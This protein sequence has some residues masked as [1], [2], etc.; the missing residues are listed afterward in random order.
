MKKLFLI[1]GSGFIFRAFY[2]LPPL[3]NPEGTPINAVYGY[4]NMI[5]NIYEKFK[6]EQVIV[7]F[8]TKKKTFRNE[9]YKQYKSNRSEPPEELIPQFSIIREATDALQIPRV[10]I[11]G[12]EADDIIATYAKRAEKKGISVTI[13][14]SDKD[15]MQLVNKNVKMYDSMKDNLIG[16]KEVKLKFGVDPSKIID[17]QALAGDKVDNIPGVSGIGIKTAAELINNFNTLENVLQKVDEIKQPKRRQTLIDEKDIAIISKKLVTLKNDIEIKNKY[18]SDLFKGINREKA[19]VFFEK[20]GFKNLIS[21]FKKKQDDSTDKEIS[22]AKSQKY[23]VIQTLKDLKSLENKIQ[24]KKLVSVDTETNSLNANF[25][26]LVGIS[27]SINENEAY[28]LPFKHNLT[29]EN[30]YKNLNLSE[31]LP[32]LKNFLEEQSVAKIGHNIKYDKIVLS[33]IGINLNSIEDTMLLSYV[34]D[35]GKIRHNLDDLAKIYLNHDN[36]KYKD[37]VGVG[38]K[39]KTFDNVSI[40]DA[41]VY[42]AEDADITLKLYKILKK[43]VISEKLLSVYEY[44]EKP[45]IDVLVKMEKEGIKIDI[46]QIKKLGEIFKKKLLKIEKEIFVLSGI[47]FNIA[48]PKQ[49]GEILFDKM[50]LEGGKKGKSG[51]YS[52]SVDVLENLSYQGHEIAKNLLEWRQ[53]SKLINT[54]TESLISEVN[55]KTLRI[56]TSYSMAATST[57]RLSSTDPNLQNIPIRSEEGKKIRNTFIS[58]DGFKLVSLDYSQIELRLLAHIGKVEDLKKAFDQNIDVHKKTASQIFNID[59]KDV[60]DELRRKA[61]T[62]N[63]GIIYG[64]SAFGLAKQLN[65]KRTEADIILKEYFKNYKGILN[66]IDKTT[67]FCRKHGFVNTLFGRKCYIDGINNNNPKFRN[68]AVRAAINAPIQGTAADII[69]KAMININK[70]LEEKRFKSRMILQ[71]HDELLFEMHKSEINYLS[72]DIKKI[73]ENSALPEIKLDIPLIV[74]MGHGASWAEAH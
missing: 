53:L 1:D 68:F 17:V 64:I 24:K 27:L 40:E 14:S 26:N 22:A 57:G 39:E 60:T 16:V 71:V 18:D 36:I 74:D 9:I 38:K 35:A 42:A 12:Y 33:N 19:L 3:T 50:E 34:L 7:V 61:K 47:E 51:S 6:P 46:N 25:A 69:K 43:R 59:I 15:L 55:K 63:Y 29:S 62:I 32:I 67:E 28:Y 23:H 41:Y 49:L 10:E 13:V 52:T 30:K 66:Y 45:L 21:R 31:C 11:D 37:I 44:I 20:H 56:H 58:R 73:M 8:D 2:A 72:M 65:I 4:C 48:S 5:L 70:F 54:Y